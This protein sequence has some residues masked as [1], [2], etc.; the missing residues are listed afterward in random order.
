MSGNSA[1]D[2]G[3]KFWMHDIYIGSALSPV[4]AAKLFDVN[5]GDLNRR[6]VSWN[7]FEHNKLLINQAANRT[8]ATSGG[9]VDVAFLLGTAFEFDAR[10][11]ASDDFDGDGRADLLVVENR[12]PRPGIIQQTLHLLGNRLPSGDDRHW[13][14]VRLDPTRGAT[15]GATIVV[16]SALGEQPAVITSGDGWRSQQAAMAHF[17]LGKTKR[18]DS[19]EIHWPGGKVS[20]LDRPRIDAY[21]TVKPPE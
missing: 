13:I 15:L 17:G 18:I 3:P 19:I 11:A 1:R 4:A 5:L 8:G 9:F 7:G 20:K 16:K 10:A 12:S 2:Y 21:H 6:D 14:G